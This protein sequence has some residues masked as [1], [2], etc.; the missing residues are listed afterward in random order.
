VIYHGYAD[1]SIAVSTDKGLVTPVLRN[2]E[3][4]GFAEIEA[5]IAATPRR[6]AKAA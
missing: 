1:I 3:R 5:A 6:R 2:V 4:M